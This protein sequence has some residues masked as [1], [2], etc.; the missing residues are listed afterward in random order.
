M[1]HI[2]LINPDPSFIHL[3]YNGE[4]DLDGRK[5]ARDEV[6]QVCEE[7]QLAR[8][9][10]DMRDSDIK[11]SEKDVVQFATGF[12]RAKLFPNYRLACVVSP[13]NQ[14]ESLLE[15]MINMEG[16]NVK[17]FLSFDDALSWLTAV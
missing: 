4:V 16:I 5:L 14:I 13:H 8:V 1:P 6:F 12:Q 11:M 10:V 15:I 9:L 7:H 2:L 3:T 17:Y